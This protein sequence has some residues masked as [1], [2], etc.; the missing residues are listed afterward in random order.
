MGAGA[1]AAP[2]GGPS[3]IYNVR[4]GGPNSFPRDRAYDSARTG[5][6]GNYFPASAEDMAGP[7]GRR[8]GQPSG[9][10]TGTLVRRPPIAL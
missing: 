3:P 8:L 10:R 9:P 7:Y 5:F 6:T 4:A 1:A 2:G